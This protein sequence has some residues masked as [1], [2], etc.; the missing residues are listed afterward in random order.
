MEKVKI[1]DKIKFGAYKWVVLDIQNDKALIITKEPVIL[2]PYHDQ[3]TEVTWENCTLRQYLNGEFFDRFRIMEK[4]RIAE[5]CLRNADNQ[6]FGTPGGNDTTDKIFIL[7]LEEV[8]K[9]FGDSGQLLNGNPN[10]IDQIFDKYNFARK[11]TYKLVGVVMWWLRSPGGAGNRAAIV[12]GDGRI[13]VNG[14]NLDFVWGLRCV[15]P[16]LWLTL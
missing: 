14:A 2:K 10:H 9:Y 16:S 8:V 1:G 3:R 4:P 13:L 7:S 6:W 11:A 5:T 12:G 15:R